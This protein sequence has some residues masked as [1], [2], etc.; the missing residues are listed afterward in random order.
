MICTPLAWAFF[1]AGRMASPL[2]VMR[3]VLAPAVTMFSMAVIWAA[4]SPSFLPE[5]LISL[6]PSFLASA[7]APSFIL[8]KKGLVSVLVI[9]PMMG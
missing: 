7:C 4:V 5:A 1:T 3:M 8:T 2:E 9:R 6:A